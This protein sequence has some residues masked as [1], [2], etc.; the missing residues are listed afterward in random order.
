RGAV[1]RHIK[2]S[3]QKFPADIVDNVQ[4]VPAIVLSGITLDRA[5]DLAMDDEAK[6]TLKKWETVRVVIRRYHKD[7]RYQDIAIDIPQLLYKALR[8]NGDALYTEVSQMDD[9]AERNKKYVSDLR[10]GLDTW[11][12]TCFHIGPAMETQLLYHFKKREDR[13]PLLEDQRLLL[14]CKRQYVT[15]LQKVYNNSKDGSW[16]PVTRIEID[17]TGEPYVEG[18][19]KEVQGWLIK[20]MREFRNPEL[21]EKGP[22]MPNKTDRDNV[23]T[24]ARSEVHKLAAAFFC[25]LPSEGRQEADDKAYFREQR[26]TKRVSIRPTMSNLVQALIDAETSEQDMAKLEA[27]YKAVD[28]AVRQTKAPKAEVEKLKKPVTKKGK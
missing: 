11:I 5:E 23:R 27:A 7:H 21:R 10:N 9:G 28:D 17:N 3:R 20:K 19:N 15:E 6:K 25:G 2:A 16:T 13:R 18:G 14:D 1:A 26:E 8:G 12:R 4:S 22:Q 24:S